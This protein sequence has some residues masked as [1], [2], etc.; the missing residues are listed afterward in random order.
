MIELALAVY[1][2][3]G[4]DAEHAGV[5]LAS[6]FSHTKSELRVHLLHDET[7]R[8]ADKIKLLRLTRRFG[9]R[10]RFY[11]VILPADM[12]EAAS[13]MPAID[14]RTTA[15]LFGLLLPQYIHADKV[16]YLDGGAVVRLD[17]GELWAIDV[18]DCYLGAVRDREALERAGDIVRCGLNP[19]EYFDSGVSVFALDTIRRRFSWYD[20]MLQF[21]QQ[22]PTASVP[23][24]DTLNALYGGNFLPL[25]SRFNKPF[26]GL[27]NDGENGIF[28]TSGPVGSE[29][30]NSS[31]FECYRQI[32]RDTPWNESEPYDEDEG[33]E[34]GK[35]LVRPVRIGSLWRRRFWRKMADPMRK[36]SRKLRKRGRVGKGRGKLRQRKKVRTP[37]KPKAAVPRRRFRQKRERPGK[38][39]V[40]PT[41]RAV[42]PKKPLAAP[43]K[44]QAVPKKRPATPV[45]P[46]ARRTD[47]RLPQ[48]VERSLAMG[49]M[50]AKA[51]VHPRFN[52]IRERLRNA[53]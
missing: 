24:R 27:P 48:R 35:P 20:D 32:W 22:F 21:M 37:N 51:W 5:A 43:G 40:V 12:L 3:D 33:E 38:K 23:G 19:N 1:D 13:R 8:A 9:H 36:A 31:S 53:P 25:D 11:R 39:Q 50:P 52:E 17:I 46:P 29:S 4:S 28:R 10:I 45:A 2:R 26:T 6:V 47:D 34:D 42:R 41:K 18:G 49:F 14:A 15:S 44:R 16:I 7:L 30:V